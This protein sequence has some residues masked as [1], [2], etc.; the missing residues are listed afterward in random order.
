MQ[1][2]P[3]ERGPALSGVGRLLYGVGGRPWQWLLSLVGEGAAAPCSLG[4]PAPQSP[5]LGGVTS[6]VASVLT[7]H[8]SDRCLAQGVCSLHDVE[9]RGPWEAN[10][11][12]SGL[13]CLE[14]AAFPKTLC[15]QV[16]TQDWFSR[17]GVGPGPH[18]GLVLQG[19]GG[20]TSGWPHT[21]QLLTSR[22]DRSQAVAL[23]A[24]QTGRLGWS[25]GGRGH[26]EGACTVGCECA[27]VI[28]GASPGYCGQTQ[29]ST[30]LV[31]VHAV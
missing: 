18:P 10:Q 19:G 23:V 17:E 21:W 26:V 24:K 6:K 27:D 13:S 11:P 3:N 12:V 20:P 7:V 28:S 2:S 31:P 30:R 1:L 25:V 9:Q 29:P 5:F 4:S 16:R 22:G 8:E 15:S 14:A